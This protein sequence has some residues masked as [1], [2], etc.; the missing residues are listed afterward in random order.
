MGIEWPGHDL[1]LVGIA[2]GLLVVALL[3]IRLGAQPS[4]ATMMEAG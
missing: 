4:R 2:G 1:A 3:G